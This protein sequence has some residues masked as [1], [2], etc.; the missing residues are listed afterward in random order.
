LG[1]KF[2]VVLYGILTAFLLWLLTLV[3]ATYEGILYPVVHDFRIEKMEPKGENK[4]W[5]WVS[6]QKQR[7]CEYIGISWYY[8]FDTPGLTTISRRELNI[9]PLNQSEGQDLNRPRGE[10][11]DGPWEVNMSM[12]DIKNHSLLTTTHR[13]HPLYITRSYLID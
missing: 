1:K 9:D 2:F 10:H 12:D 13:C 6:F 4:T 5:V 3:G 11:I 7:D 8:K